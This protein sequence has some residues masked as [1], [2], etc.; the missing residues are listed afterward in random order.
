MNDWNTKLSASSGLWLCLLDRFAGEKIG[1][2]DT[3]HAL[4]L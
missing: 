3:V 4:F 2:Q 1:V